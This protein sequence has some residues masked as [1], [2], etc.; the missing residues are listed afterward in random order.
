[1]CELLVFTHAQLRRLP[2]LSRFKWCNRRVIPPRHDTEHGDHSE[3]FQWKS[4]LWTR[5]SSSFRAQLC[6][7]QGRKSGGATTSEY[8]IL[9]LAPCKFH[10]LLHSSR[11][12]LRWPARGWETRHSIVR[13]WTPFPHDTEHSLHSPCTNLKRAIV[14]F[15][16]SNIYLLYMSLFYEKGS[17]HVLANYPETLIIFS[18]QDHRGIASK[19][20]A[21]LNVTALIPKQPRM[22]RERFFQSESILLI[23]IHSFHQIPEAYISSSRLSR[24][25]PF[26]N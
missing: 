15:P 13:D 14:L 23:D 24:F 9:P 19:G 26:L 17:R 12:N 6:M 11:G 7:E 1:M 3:C 8:R 22:S 18:M 4:S 10:S 2:V 16:L 25:F 21:L 20:Y 5:L